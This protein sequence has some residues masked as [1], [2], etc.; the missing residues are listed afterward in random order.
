MELVEQLLP[1]LQYVHVVTI[2]KYIFFKIAL[3][4]LTFEERKKIM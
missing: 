3:K 1:N 2:V 4:A